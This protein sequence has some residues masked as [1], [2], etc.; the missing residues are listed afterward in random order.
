MNIQQLEYII[1]VDRTK[2]FTKAAEQ[3]F[4]TQATL[5]AMIKKLEEELEV[6]LFD[7]KGSPVITTEIGQVIL[8]EARQVLIHSHKIK[9]LVGQQK[10]EI[11][12]SLRIGIIPTIASS[13]LPRILKL[14]STRFPALE[15]I[16]TEMITPEVVEQVRSGR[17]DAGIIATPWKDLNLEEIILYYETLMVYG[18]EQMERKYIMPYEIQDKKIWMLEEG[19]CLR[20]QFINYCSLKKKTDMPG[21]LKFEGNSF[22]TLLNLV[23]SFGGLTLIPELYYRLLSE[24]KK[25]KVR[26]F[27]LPIPV[28][29]VSMIYHR[30]YAR[31]NSLQAV[32]GL[33]QA[34]INQNL[35]SS[36]F[37]KKDLLIV[38]I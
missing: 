31:L 3:C 18:M 5:S 25:L 34:E 1:A 13:L 10:G 2:N 20:E 24:D 35:I 14:L 37:A 19:H 9:D 26:Q 33:I 17:L 30:P 4:V 11:S 22:E 36:S 28:R 16:V 27:S 23:D 15:L 21:N 7:R 6:I 8:D 12:G 38:E 32:S 29:E